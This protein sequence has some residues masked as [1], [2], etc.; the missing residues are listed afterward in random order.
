[1]TNTVRISNTNMRGDRE[2]FFPHT[3]SLWNKLLGDIVDCT[4]DALFSKYLL[5]LYFCFLLYICDD[6]Q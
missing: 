1:M 2:T 3:I 4:T 6:I 5:N